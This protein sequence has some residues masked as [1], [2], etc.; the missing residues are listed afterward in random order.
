MGGG[1][2]V[3]G[4]GGGKNNHKDPCSSYTSP[5]SIKYR[6]I[7][8]VLACSATMSGS[9]NWLTRPHIKLRISYKPRGSKNIL[10]ALRLISGPYHLWYPLCDTLSYHGFTESLKFAIASYQL[11]KP[12][13]RHCACMG[14][15]LVKL[16]ISWSNKMEQAWCD[17]MVSYPKSSHSKNRKVI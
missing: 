13:K 9:R 2:V 4:M 10:L 1:W 11:A 8:S 3:K 12:E 17:N 16:V 15:A 7:L 14:S 6:P 5:R